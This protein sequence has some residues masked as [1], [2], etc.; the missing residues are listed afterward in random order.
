MIPVNY[1]K[2]LLPGT[3]EYTLNELLNEKIDLE[4][5]YENIKNDETGAPAYD[6]AILLKIILFS[7]SRGII[8]SRAIERFCL[9]NIVCIALSAD[10]VPHFTTIAHFIANNGNAIVSLFKKVL[11]MGMI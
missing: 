2:Q 6:P 7:Y 10:T 9:E 5:F 1:K 11:S 3:Y 8:S 4:P